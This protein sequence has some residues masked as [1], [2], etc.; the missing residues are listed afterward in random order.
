MHFKILL[1]V[2][3]IFLLS[4]P[5]ECWWRRR[6]RRRSPPP[7]P[8][9][10][11]TRPTFISCP[12]PYT[13]TTSEADGRI[14][15][16]YPTPTATDNRGTPSVSRTSGPA[17][18]SRFGAGLT[19][20]TYQATDGAGNTRICTIHITVTVLR[21]SSVPSSS[22]RTH[23]CS[24][25][26]I[27]GS[28]CTFTCPTTG[29]HVVGHS[30]ST[31]RSSSTWSHS[32][33]TCQLTTCSPSLTSISHGTV[34]C[35]NSN[36][37]GS[38]CTFRCSSGYGFS[39]GGSS[40]TRYR[41][42][43]SSWSGSTPSCID[44]QPPSFSYC[45][46]PI[47]VVAED[48]VTSAIV[49][50]T[51]PTATDNVRIGLSVQKQQGAGSGSRFSQGSHTIRYRATD[52]QG[53]TRDC[54]F[55][56]TVR[57]ITCPAHQS[58]P[59]LVISCPNGY[60]KGASCS[61]QCGTGYQLSRAGSS[62]C[63]SSGS[64]S[65]P[66]P[67]CQIRSCPALTA[68]AHGSFRDG[69]SC[70][71]TYD[72]RCNFECDTGYTLTGS[73]VRRCTIQ[74]N[75]AVWGGTTTGC[76][77]NTCA[78]LAP[79]EGLNPTNT[80]TCSAGHHV[81]YG[82]TCGYT[83]ATGYRLTGSRIISCG[84]NGQ[85]LQPL[86]VCEE[87]TCATNALPTPAN[88]QRSNCNGDSVS[89]GTRCTLSCNR[90]YTPRTPVTRVCQSGSNHLGVWS[91]GTISC[92]IITCP[93]PIVPNHGS[94]SCTRSGQTR[95]AISS[96]P[97]DTSCSYSC[98]N[99]YTRSGPA[100]RTCLV[101][102]SWDGSNPLCTD[103]TAPVL[104]CP[105]DKVFFAAEGQTRVSINWNWEPVVATDVGHVDI[106]AVV[107]TINSVAVGV[108][109]PTAF[110]EGVYS[111]VYRATDNAGNQESC[112][113][114]VEAKVTRCPG[115]P[116][117][118]NGILSLVAGQGS[119]ADG[120]V[121]GSLCSFTCETGHTLSSEGATHLR[122]CMRNT[123]Q[124][125]DG[126]WSGSQP[127][128]EVN[129]C[130]YPSITNG[131]IFGCHGDTA[132]YED[133][134]LF[135]CDVGRRTTSGQQ[136]RTRQCRADGSW[137]GAEFQCT[138]VVTCPGPFSLPDGSVDPAICSLAQALPYN[139]ECDFSCG[140]GFVQQGPSSK[141]CTDNASWD[142][143]GAVTCTDEQRPQFDGTCPQDLTVSSEFNRT[144]RL[145]NFDVPSANDNSG[146][147]T[148][149]KQ[150]NG[151]GPGSRF[152]E[153]RTIVTYI[154]VDPTG[155]SDQCDVIITVNV[156][157]C[158]RLL[159]PSS[160]SVSCNNPSPIAG[161][162]CSLRCNTGYTM[163]GSHTRTCQVSTD[164]TPYWEGQT[165]VCTIVRCPSETSPPNSIKS[166]C[167]SEADATE[168]Y[169][170]QCSFYCLNGY[171]AETT[172][173]GRSRCLADGSWSGTDLVCNEIECQTLY[174]GSGVEV[175]PSVCASQ[176][177]FG[178]SC[179]FT[180][181]QSGFRV[182][183]L[184]SMIVVCQGNG[185]WS[186]DVTQVHCIDIESPRFADCPSFLTVY[187]DRGTTAAQFNPPVSATD[188]NGQP[189]VSC[190]PGSDQYDIG[191]YRFNC[192]AEDAAG[193]SDTCSFDVEVLERRCHTLSPPPFGEFVGEC[194]S[195]YGSKCHLKCI[196]YYRLV[197]SNEATCE[198]NGTGT[199][200][201]IEE[202]PHCELITCDTISLPDIV[203]VTPSICSTGTPPTGST[204]SLYC[205]N[206]LT[207]IGGVSSVSCGGQGLWD[208]DLD[209]VN[210]NCKDQIPP[211]LTSCP[212]SIITLKSEEPSGTSV[213]FD[214][215]TVRDNLP[216]NTLTLVTSPSDITS[217]YLFTQTLTE[218]SYNFT[219]HGGNSV[220][221]KFTVS[222]YDD[223]VPEVVFCPEDYEVVGDSKITSVTW[224]EPVFR[225]PTGHD[226]EVNNN[227]AEGNTALLPWGRHTVV[228][229]ASNNDNGQKAV[230]QFTIIVERVGCISLD[231]PKN[232]ALSCIPSGDV[233]S[234][235]CNEGYEISR[236]RGRGRRP[237]A[238]THPDQYVCS[239]SGNWMPHSIVPDCSMRRG[240]TQLPMDL[241][242]FSGDCR[243]QSTQ[244]AIAEAFIQMI[245]SS[246]YMDS[247]SLTNKC[248]IENIQ[249]IC[250]TVGGSSIGGRPRIYRRGVDH[251]LEEDEQSPLLKKL[252]DGTRR[253]RRDAEV[254]YA[255]FISFNLKFEVNYEV[256]IESLDAV[257]TT[258]T[259]MKEEAEVLMSAFG[260]GTMEAMSVSNVT[261]E[262]ADEMM[263]YG[264]S[265]LTCELGY[266]VSNETYHCTA[267]SSGTWY[268][269]V[270]DDCEFCSKGSYQDQQ[271]KEE[272]VLCPSGT[273]TAAEGAKTS[274]MC[275]AVCPAGQY[276]ETGLVPC[277]KCL[278]GEYQ[279]ET[280][281][282]SC[283]TCLEEK[284]TQN[285]GSQ[286]LNQCLE[287]C[288]PGSYS[289]TGLA[290]CLPCEPRYY[291]PS[292]GKHHCILC[293]GRSTTLI[294][295]SS[296]EEDCID[297]DEC[298]SSPCGSEATCIDLINGYRCDCPPGY[299]GMNC[300]DDVD[301][302]EGNMCGNNATCVDG[303]ATYQ[304]LCIPGFEGHFCEL[305]INECAES[306]CLND[307]ICQDAVAGYRCQ[308]PV[309]YHGTNCELE[310]NSC[311]PNPCQNDGI[312]V[313]NEGR[314]LCLCR[315]GFS[316]V[317]CSININDCASSPC[318][319]GAT[320]HDLIA[321]V[322]CECPTGYEGEFC[323]TD[324]DLCA[325]SP[326]HSGAECI[327]LGS[328]FMCR[329]PLHRSGPRCEDTPCQNSAVFVL[330]ENME[331]YSCR[332][333][334][335]YTG[336]NCEIDFDECASSPCSN[337]GVCVEH[338]LNSFMCECPQGFEGDTCSIDINE[339]SSS[340]CGIL[341]ICEDDENGY[342]CHCAPGLTG[343]HCENHIDYCAPSM[344]QHGG[345]CMIA[346]LGYQCVCAAG[347]TGRDCEIN[348]N[349]CSPVPCQNGGIC[350]DRDNG[351]LCFCHTGSRGNQCEVNIDDC[352]PRA[353]QNG[354]TCID[355]IAQ[356][357]CICPEGFTGAHCEE[358][359]NFCLSNPC[360]N[361]GVCQNGPLGY[362]CSCTRG[363]TGLNCEEDFDSCVSFP[364]MHDSTCVDDVIGFIC[365][366]APGYAG[367]NCEDNIN[368]CSSSPCVNGG[369]C[370]DQIGFYVCLCVE[371][372]TG[373]NCE[374]NVNDCATDECLNGAVCHDLVNAFEC[375]C[376]SGWTGELCEENIDD[377]ELSPCMNG[378]TC[379]DFLNGYECGCQHGYTGINC[380]TEINECLQLN[381]ECQHGA[382]CFD[383][384]AD[385]E[386]FC[387]EGYRGRYCEVDVDECE[388]NPC[389]NGGVC[390]D[391]EARYT[392]RCPTGF[393]GLRCET[394][395][396][397][398]ED[399]PCSNDATC[400]PYRGGFTCSCAIGYSGDLCDIEI[401]ECISQPCY[402]QGTC[403]DEPGGYQCVCLP[404]YM[405]VHCETELPYDFDLVF[406][407]PTESDLIQVTNVTSHDLDAI[408]VSLWMRS[409]S[410]FS[411]FILLKLSSAWNTFVEIRDPTDLSLKL[412]SHDVSVDNQDLC[413]GRWHNL[414][415]TLNAANQD[416]K[417]YIDKSLSAEGGIAS[418]LTSFPSGLTL[419]MGPSETWTGANSVEIELGNVNIWRN[420]LDEVEVQDL[421]LYCVPF[422]PG[423]VFAWGQVETLP[424]ATITQ[425]LSVPSVCDDY[426]ECS[427]SPCESGSTC[428]DKIGSY[429]CHCAV[430]WEGDRCQ[431]MTDFCLIQE[432]LN[433]GTCMASLL[434]FSCVCQ[435][436]YT[437]TICET[438]IINGQWSPWLPW[439]ECSQSCGSG[440]RFRS[441]PCDNPS[442]ENGGERCQ[443]TNV[444]AETCN[445]EMCPT[446]PTLRRPY[447]GYVDCNTTDTGEQ[448]CSIRCR[449]GYEFNTT[450]QDVYRCGP[451][452]NHRW[453][454]NPYN[455]RSRLP[456]CNVVVP[457]VGAAANVTV[458]YPSLQCSSSSDLQS[459]IQTASGLLN[460]TQGSSGC[461]ALS[462][463]AANISVSNCESSNPHAVK[464]RS[465]SPVKLTIEV[466]MDNST[467]APVNNS[468]EFESEFH[469]TLQDLA[470][471]LKT[472]HFGISQDGIIMQPDKDTVHLDSWDMCPTGYVESEE[473]GYCVQ[474][475]LG[476][477]CEL[478]HESRDYECHLC[479]SNTYR[480][481]WGTSVCTKCPDGMV[482][483]TE[484]AVNSSECYAF[485][486]PKEDQKTSSESM[487]LMA[488]CGLG[489][490]IGVFVFLLA[491]TYRRKQSKKSVET[492]PSTL[493]DVI[494]ILQLMEPDG[495]SVSDTPCA[496]PV[497]D[498]F[499]ETSPTPSDDPA[500]S[501]ILHLPNT[502]L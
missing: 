76:Q 250:G 49:T 93:R 291:Q 101:S 443:G 109:K 472:R 28:V 46:N 414:V 13:R 475:G 477:I 282:T 220:V 175:F 465:V 227:L 384:V 194:R 118:A 283:L 199:F 470:N 4:T 481:D 74:Q 294:T 378:G 385:F 463:C 59:H 192:V 336:R 125:V 95:P 344:C 145:V 266:V 395:L 206:A 375:S 40:S 328:S 452:T 290:P 252:E 214:I 129:T 169:G 183:P 80:G 232:G 212:S 123:D 108:T 304:C 58:S 218:V 247:C 159:A 461:L 100:S 91:A 182:E 430:G 78:T 115:L 244:D 34:T 162:Q 374:Q 88:G 54:T 77:I 70:P 343:T 187:T 198:F 366:C 163:S 338:Q 45:P 67:T 133:S 239:L 104:E 201:E 416:W 486:T 296:T 105:S 82:S 211:M 224:E 410:C 371:G 487:M 238:S 380:Q 47:S 467:H 287:I 181:T 152:P 314:Y 478:S 400:S 276:S 236:P 242:Y 85:W 246:P 361:S 253:R 202:G 71:R 340:P 364:C 483:Y 245:Q 17:S 264:E 260:N 92:T 237:R 339:C 254:T 225:D 249:V 277:S 113:L 73:S 148:V 438:E 496:S 63:R 471:L 280:G 20:I 138:V 396:N 56:I 24:K 210:V 468:A 174:P 442:P 33:P 14:V 5:A 43:G 373:S 255:A 457:R 500:I 335:G 404:G 25:T 153:G 219:D 154:A 446:C 354:G 155:N 205:L 450:P 26:N 35:S 492:N 69:N 348:I 97:F 213:T 474:C 19:T 259:K 449:D 397:L 391:R 207:L 466:V 431:I 407:N 494:D 432:C 367:F 160:G 1:V 114:Q 135:R 151:R 147:V 136:Y 498:A 312:C 263:S 307:A 502:K 258:E 177:V 22:H 458:D 11:T 497:G 275:E 353:C 235:F 341:S 140:N 191:N 346:E 94:I 272:C 412:L 368:E 15:V 8:P 428:E 423:D 269:S 422:S 38:R 315:P 234:I 141:T 195:V 302:C 444:Q 439:T 284:T 372:Y 157:R 55:T 369:V 106:T 310:I 420:A 39:S 99:G 306:P 324:I 386:C 320:C 355:G 41:T 158:E 360:Q 102:G 408:T 480:E 144:S 383:K 75:N 362:Q 107:V 257:V 322:S 289:E 262:V 142:N 308:C 479:P 164:D 112:S 462:T 299:E 52:A 435:D 394:E 331:M 57:V 403:E 342:T 209:E 68:P 31:C 166:G 321:E 501:D 150:G 330:D 356:F 405:G 189:T 490:V 208:V 363:Y 399:E 98:N 179:M 261:L 398:C 124:S 204:C 130:S 425:L 358:L 176:P 161:T 460:S 445:E 200:W 243:D 222:V 231:Q 29:Y 81:N 268:N 7:P 429:D 311:S 376:Q 64:W 332:C 365:N 265:K 50:Y 172:D 440:R 326:C 42:C 171:E 178:N 53:N 473:D 193:N 221:C 406:S 132:T 36:Y 168:T 203:H 411:E 303:L 495:K 488:I 137:S 382:S 417:I 491:V 456:S 223:L 293:P 139:T 409:T 402:H 184:G 316:G 188:N 267:C 216:P 292:S 389:Q 419:S 51:T 345:T 230:C 485:E 459:I 217:P 393:G 173:N 165:T 23:S 426:D 72:S 215:P 421:A 226:L 381:V 48:A 281:K 401:N 278:L 455:A 111:I 87:I 128:C 156:H 90:G 352:T 493:L 359:I 424:G 122:R 120:P 454:F 270:T 197:G 44:T 190:D 186:Q 66:R 413:N 126:F 319:H 309:N 83:C 298:S 301:D 143:T 317:N 65:L 370:V 489:I 297:A 286:S 271:A 134:C 285:F 469:T 196:D 86:P 305:N 79:G 448:S 323:Q 6:R 333:V 116:T 167:S 131:N 274:S 241:M 110:D 12:G 16:S 313:L 149:S 357:S 388:S 436:G 347:F 482:T 146:L 484:G 228:Y 248:N 349:D 337:G 32:F 499:P 3:A 351:F 390:E 279:P 2:L 103:V 37:Y 318:Q 127:Y 377:C 89:Y 392:C 451:S 476:S 185:G 10:D 387:Q 240:Q 464:R 418:P 170:T 453:D 9:P 180:C 84:P 295:G 329:C 350:I 415:L 60:I 433:G 325:G 300:Q 427:S 18:G 256:G 121:Y 441:R 434:S 62:L 30:T 21:C 327:D 61:F 437:G 233:C 119:C 117:P 273:S 229:T 334:A 288:P 379:S 96:L 251:L 447:R 27:A